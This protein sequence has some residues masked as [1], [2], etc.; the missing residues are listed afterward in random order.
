MRN[1]AN[2]PVTLSL[3]RKC[4]LPLILC[5]A[6]ALSAAG[7][8]R[9]MLGIDT[10]AQNGFAQIRGKRVGLLTHPAGVNRFGQSTIDVLRAAQGLRLV[11]LYGPEHGIYGDEKANVKVKSRVDRRTRLPVYSLY[12]D[13]RKPTPAMLRNIDLLV[14]DLQDIGARSYTYVS[15]MLYAMEACFEQG[16]EVVVLDRPNP[17]GGL[18]VDGPPLEAKWRSYVGSFPAPYVLGLTI[19]EIAR[20]AKSRSGWLR[21][22]DRV[23]ERGKLTL[24]T[25]RGWGRSMLWQQTGLKWVPTS[26]AIPT[27]QAA[28]GYAMTG[29]GCQLGGWQH[30]YG[31]PYPFRLL[32]FPGKTPQQIVSALRARAIPGLNFS[33]R[34]YQNALGQTKSGAYVSI[35]DWN[36]LHP[37]EL[38]FH[39]LDLAARWTAHNPFSPIKNSQADLFNKHFGASDWWAELQTRGAR[40]GLPIRAYHAR[41]DEYARQFQ[42]SVRRYWLY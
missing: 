5:A 41:W 28:F 23:R 37:V 13:T 21:C 2:A 30:G 36:A 8:P 22:S 9:V 25:M 26:P 14:I 31:T 16:K 42:Q 39:L 33:V 40:G 27:P 32:T 38:S 15:C 29:L 24:V 17:L 3:L 35:T 11:A 34:S 10:L 12:G 1:C 4:L 19:A 6:T 7:V 18:K 20:I